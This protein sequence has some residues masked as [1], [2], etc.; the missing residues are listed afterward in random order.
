MSILGYA[1][2]RK[3]AGQEKQQ[4]LLEL[5]LK[6]GSTFPTGELSKRAKELGIPEHMLA[7]LAEPIFGDTPSLSPGRRAPFG[8]QGVPPPGGQ[9][10]APQR[11][12][13]YR[14]KSEE[15]RTWDKTQRQALQKARLGI[16]VAVMEAQKEALIAG[17]VK[18]A[19]QT[20][21][22]D[23]ETRLAK[24]KSG[25]AKELEILK[26]QGASN[27][28][29]QV[30]NFSHW[31][32]IERIELQDKL[33]RTPTDLEKRKIESEIAENEAQ[34]RYA[35][36]LANWVSGGKGE[37]E[38]ELKE[39][40]SRL[41]KLGFLKKSKAGQ[42]PKIK[43]F[44]KGSDDYKQAIAIFD[45]LGISFEEISAGKTW[46]GTP[47]ISKNKVLLIP[48]KSSQRSGPRLKQEKPNLSPEINLPNPMIGFSVEGPTFKAIGGKEMEEMDKESRKYKWKPAD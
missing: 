32:Q 11:V 45:T 27:T 13:G 3:E 26:Q 15:E 42:I 46:M 24:I 36:V 16:K 47:L 35:D 25:Y 33:R 9:K 41:G 48:V 44:V 22:L 7:Q 19:E 20:V 43:S 23:K 29:F 4:G 31:L 2:Q 21:M 14:I 37:P 38:R 8:D 17:A 12:T 39:L 28:R 5:I 6:Y 18:S 1:A 34:T 30:A 40:W 10:T